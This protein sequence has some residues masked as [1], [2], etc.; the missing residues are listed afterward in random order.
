MCYTDFFSEK[1]QT[2][3]A[4]GLEKVKVVNHFTTGYVSTK[5]K[6]R[7]VVKRLS[8]QKELQCFVPHLHIGSSTERGLACVS[9]F[10][11]GLGL[12]WAWGNSSKAGIHSATQQVPELGLK[13]V[14]SSFPE[15]S[16]GVTN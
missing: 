15:G 4:T 3:L 14:S 8:N 11:F 6:S 5:I 1:L 9:F 13:S 2:S 7:P 12:F 16:Q 10:W